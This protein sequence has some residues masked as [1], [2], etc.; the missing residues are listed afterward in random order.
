MSQRRKA[1]NWLEWCIFGGGLVLVL[2]TV[3]YLA[4][5]AATVPHGPPQIDLKLGTPRRQLSGFAV[6]V[7]ARNRGHDTAE[8]V[9]IEVVLEPPSGEKERAIFEIQFLP[10]GATRQG[11]VTFRSNPARARKLVPRVLG[12]QVP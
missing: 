6:P 3:G 2:A 4:Y 11:T 1:K 9:H 7:M 8:A 5:Q 10:S 12:Y